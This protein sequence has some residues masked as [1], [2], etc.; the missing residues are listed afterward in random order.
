[1]RAK[2]GLF[3]VLGPSATTEEL[4]KNFISTF[5][6]IQRFTEKHH[7]P[8]IAKVYRPTGKASTDKHKPRPGRV[9]LWLDYE[10][11]SSYNNPE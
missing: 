5:P 10:G 4:A 8:F 11:W 2:A 7:P 6:A 3:F 1:M 9:E